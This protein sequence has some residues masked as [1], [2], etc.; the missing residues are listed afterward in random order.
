MSRFSGKLVAQVALNA[1]SFGY[2]RYYS[3]AVPEVW[4]DTVRIGMRVA[5]PFG[6]GNRRRIAMILALTNEQPLS[7]DGTPLRLKPI[8]GV[9]DTEPVLNDELLSLVHFLHE[10]TF[11]TRYD[12]VRA[13]LPGGMQIRL[14]EQFL[15]VTPPDGIRL[16]EE[17]ENYLSMLRK[18]RSRHELDRLLQTKG[19]QQRKEILCALEEKGCL[20]RITEGKKAAAD[21]TDKMLRLSGEYRA[22]PSAFRPTP[23]QRTALAVLEAHEM[24]SAK[25][26]AYYAGVTENVIRNLVKSGIA[27]LF[28]VELL[29]VPRDAVVTKPPEMTILSEEQEAAFQAVASAVDAGKAAAFLLYG[30]T[31]SG[32]TAVF[33]QLIAH[34]LRQGKQ[35]LLLIP[36]ISLTPQI[37]Q[38][39]QQAFGNQVALIH[40]GLSLG[41]RLDTD[42]LI[43]RG[44]VNIVIGTRSAVFAP[45]SRLGLIILDEE[46]E[47]SYKSDA[48][49]RYHAADIAKERCRYHQAALVLAS[50]TPSLESRYLAEKGVYRLLTLKQRYNQAPLP[51]VTVVDMNVERMNGNNSPFSIAL[52]DALRD[53]LSNGKQSILL[54]NRRGYHTMLQCTKC[55]TPV[56]CPNCSVPMT[57]HKPNGSLMCHYCGHIQPPVSECP[58]CG[59]DNLRKMG[60]GTQRLEEELQSLLPT[61]K[62]LRMDAD[63][64]MTR[65][66]Y[67]TGFQAFARGEYDIMC[68]TQMIGK[69]LDF[70]NVTLVGVVSIDKALYAGDFRSYERTFSLITQ[71]VG[72]SGRGEYAGRAILQT[73]MPEHYVLALAAKQDYDGFYAEELALRRALMFPPICDLCVIGLSAVLEQKVKQAAAQFIVLLTQKIQREQLKLPLRVLGP[74]EA[75]YGKLNGKYRRRILLKC[76]NTALMR[77]FIRELLSI[78]FSDKH[79]SG[80]SIYAD[81]N[82]DCGV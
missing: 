44:E 2:D 78:C 18:A 67:E 21:H 35:A 65:S 51:E 64:T 53:N 7:E 47:H 52:A 71:V 9:L 60:F 8:A 62:I 31:G 32:K 11:C 28:E 16:S 33:E 12:A 56:Y 5:V 46:G 82:G 61:A 30:V 6:S 13:V 10:R 72:R 14:Q 20:V 24:I 68:G 57:F 41:Q 19:D 74:V 76:K 25:E 69:G 3:Y 26:C 79:F 75:S 54:L 81:M 66:A 38:R 34:T 55:N 77:N 70:P 45:L 17:E 37:V 40:S 48:A 29:R 73:A 22:N 27:E 63:T 36:E 15:P 42:K 43:R 1:A 58:A 50:A 80:V 39:F 23:K 49:P 59:H 4:A